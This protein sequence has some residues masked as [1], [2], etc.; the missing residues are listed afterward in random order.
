ME[1]NFTR[2]EIPSAAPRP[3]WWRVRVE[4]IREICENVKRLRREVVATTPGGFPVYAF[5]VGAESKHNRVNWP[6][7]TG[8]P[9]P[10]VYAEND[11]QVVMVVAGIHAEETEGV[12]TALNLLSLLDTGK[13]LLGR[14]NAELLALCSRYRLVILPCVNMDGRAI[15]PDCLMGCTQ[16]DYGP[17]LTWLDDGSVL[18]WP[19]LK[20]HFP[21]PMERV[22]QLGTYYNADGYNIMLDCAPGNIHTAE[23]QALLRLADRERIDLFL[24]M[25][26]C[27]YNSHV[28]VPSVMN[29][30]GNVRTV[31]EIRRR[32]NERMG[33]AP[34][35]TPPRRDPQ[36]DINAA[37]TLA[38]GAAPLTFE[39]D[40]LTVRPFEAKVED[41][42]AILDVI[43]RLG[44]ER[45]L[46]DR[47]TILTPTPE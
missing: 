44:L 9:H 22:T 18:K 31:M 43:L 5:S 14:E 35:R 6:S 32:F 10:Q 40:A 30:P 4:E 27:T 42:Y 34:D 26:S 25:H 47:A 7:A 29:Y 28:I 41:G 36:T 11:P 12:C 8:S 1:R 16:A 3:D 20:E 13:D 33:R 46:C 15:A 38:T 24:N 45:P 19:D 39:F 2:R 21:M 23:A 37:V 17:I